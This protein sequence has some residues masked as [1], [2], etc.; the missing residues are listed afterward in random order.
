MPRRK[1]TETVRLQLTVAEATDRALEE[2][3]T[4]GILGRNK[5]EVAHWIITDWLWSN[6]EQLAR[7]GIVIGSQKGENR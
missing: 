5:A 3:A 2:M 7:S 6:A 4:M 1:A